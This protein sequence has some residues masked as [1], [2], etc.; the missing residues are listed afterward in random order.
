[1]TQYSFPWNDVNGD[2]LYDADDFM[3]FF[4]AFLKTGVVMSF[5]DGLRVRSAQNGM[6]IQVGGGS[7][8]IGGGSYLNDENIAIQ[9]NV[10]SS[11][12]N[13]TDS[14]VLRMDKNARDTYLYYKPS[15]TTVV[16]ND[17]LFELQLAT[18]SVKMNATQITDADITDMRSDST[19]CGWST[20]FDN[21]NVD[22]IVDQYTSIFEQADSDFKSWFQNLK[23][24]LDDNQAAN[25]QNQIDTIN[26]V[27][28]QKNIPDG[29]NLD[30]YKSE[31]EFS[32]KTPTIVVG[33][34]EGV[35]GAFRLSVRTM[36]GSS[37][38]FQTLYDYVTRSMYYRIGNT[39]LGFNLPWKRVATTDDIKEL[40]AG[41]TD[42]FLP[43]T[44]D[45]GF[46]ANQAEYCIK[47]GWIYITVQGARPNSTV[48]GE[49]YYTFLTLPAEI[50]AHITHN[51]GFMWSNFQGGGTTYSG[52]ILSN[53][54]V[55]LY[56]SPKTN[57]L[58]SNHRFSFNMTI[59]LRKTK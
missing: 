59:P 23:N 29:A 18:I 28:V 19:V 13:R 36:I 38:I 1:M 53:G 7:A 43:L 22:G 42:G 5:K 24:Q 54:Q 37:G 27:I 52:G 11:V 49:S 58:A 56:L 2:R 26:G 9:V 17:I 40:T 33:A 35:T 44:M 16:R 10:A 25:L 4:A 12:Q 30:E 20:P 6:N 45:K 31:G 39:T 32:K 51:E 8:V 3:R 41:D 48:T 14:V 50:T 57:S 46:T 34:P 21:I 15:D 55:Q 47:N